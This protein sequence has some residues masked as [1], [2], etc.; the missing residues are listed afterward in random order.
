MVPYIKSS[1]LITLYFT[2]FILIKFDNKPYLLVTNGIV[3]NYPTSTAI[4]GNHSKILIYFF[5]F[6]TKHSINNIFFVL[7]LSLNGPCKQ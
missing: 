4:H 1:L 3:Y 7:F 6:L 2:Y 5:I